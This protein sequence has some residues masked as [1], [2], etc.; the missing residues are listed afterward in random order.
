M[1]IFKSNELG[2]SIKSFEVNGLQVYLMEKKQ[3]SDISASFVVNYGSNDISFKYEGEKDFKQYP[4]GIAHFLEHKMFD[5]NGK[6]E[7]FKNFSEIG[8]DVNAYTSS[9]VTNYYFSTVDN[10]KQGMKYPRD[11]IYGL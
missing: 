10:F 9:N 8:A 4:L 2:E 6:D 5:G 7:V 11:M 3:F 1:K